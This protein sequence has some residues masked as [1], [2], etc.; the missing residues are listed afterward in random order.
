M[1]DT[2]M[3]ADVVRARLTQLE[4]LLDDV[5]RHVPTL[6]TVQQRQGSAMWTDIPACSKFATDY[7]LTLTKLEQALTAIR[8]NVQV[9]LVNL[10]LDARD[11]TRTEEDIR[12]RMVALAEQLNSMPV[13][14]PA[15]VPAGTSTS[16]YGST[17]SG[18]YDATMP[19]GSEAA[20]A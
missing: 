13:V 11:L 10:A 12:D 15:P 8:A 20:L 2:G 9:L 3:Q 17:M 14:P 6:R 5:D 7:T 4:L 19:S 16:G 1:V 18:G